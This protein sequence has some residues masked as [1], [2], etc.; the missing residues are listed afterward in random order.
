MTTMAGGGMTQGGGG[1]EEHGWGAGGN[2]LGDVDNNLEGMVAEPRKVSFP[3]PLGRSYLGE[4]V[5]F[6]G[7]TRGSPCAC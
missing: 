7:S 4:G 5:F 1:G 6:R 2:Y 3:Y